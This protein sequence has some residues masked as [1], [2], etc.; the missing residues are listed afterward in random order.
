MPQTDHETNYD[1]PTARSCLLRKN[2][3]ISLWFT[4]LLMRPS[5]FIPTDERNAN[6][7]RQASINIENK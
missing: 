5:G 4:I 3:R 2:G 1:Q 7:K 6:R